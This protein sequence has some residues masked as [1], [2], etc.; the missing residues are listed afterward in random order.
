VGKGII[1]H[2]EHP[3]HFDKSKKN[4]H[5]LLTIDNYFYQLT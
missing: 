4:G 1:P 5:N 3:W 2:A